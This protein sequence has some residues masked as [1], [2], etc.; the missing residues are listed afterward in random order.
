MGADGTG[1]IKLDF[2]KTEGSMAEAVEDGYKHLTDADRDA[3]AVYL[4]SPPA[5][6]NH[7]GE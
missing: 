4:N 7:F 5:I 6:E 1:C 2:E 3:I